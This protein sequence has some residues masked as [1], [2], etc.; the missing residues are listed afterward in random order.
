LVEIRA[1]RLADAAGAGKLAAARKHSRADPIQPTAAADF[2]LIP[3]GMLLPIVMI[4]M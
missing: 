4:L 1:I 2:F 3:P